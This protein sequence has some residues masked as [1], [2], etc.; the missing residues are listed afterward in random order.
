MICS[1]FLRILAL[2]PKLACF[3]GSSHAYEHTQTSSW[4]CCLLPGDGPQVGEHVLSMCKALDLNPRTTQMNTVI[5]YFFVLC[6]FPRTVLLSVVQVPAVWQVDS[7]GTDIVI[8]QQKAEI[9]FGLNGTG[10]HGLY[11]ALEPDSGLFWKRNSVG[12]QPCLRVYIFFRTASILFSFLFPPPPL[13]LILISFSS[14]LFPFLPPFIHSS[15]Y[16]YLELKKQNP[17]TCS[18][19]K[20]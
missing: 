19:Q 14:F 13:S 1:L 15:K 6:L 16:I 7:S 5:V 18:C 9:T 2:L 3:Q 12:T 10:S 17:K 11:S 20:K 4:C 8:G